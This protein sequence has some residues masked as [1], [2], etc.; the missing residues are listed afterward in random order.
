MKLIQ[1]EQ[2]ARYANAADLIEDLYKV[3]SN[4]GLG[5]IDNTLEIEDSP[6]QVIPASPSMR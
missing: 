6:T 1:K 4:I 5:N 3:K 2:S